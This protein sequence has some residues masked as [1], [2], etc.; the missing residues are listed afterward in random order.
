MAIYESG[1]DYLEA[2]FILGEKNG[3]VRSIDVASYMNYSK[4]SV[5]RAMSI[6]REAG[7]IEFAE[8]G[9]IRLT[10]SGEQKAS[11]VYERHR[12]IT[13]FLVNVLGVERKTAEKDACR[14]E[15]D[16]SD[17]TFEKMKSFGL[18]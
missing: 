12:I 17:E 10:A 4:P 9:A 16:L 14:I 11:G 2:I 7:L 8:N 5:S 18:S 1:E 13:D 6:L 3:N 15:H